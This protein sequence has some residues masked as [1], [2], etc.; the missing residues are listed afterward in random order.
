[1]VCSHAARLGRLNVLAG[2]IHRPQAQPRL[3]DDRAERHRQARDQHGAVGRLYDARTT[4]HLYVIDPAGILVYAGGIDDIRS[5]KVADIAQA[6]NLVTAALADLK[7][8]RPVRTKN[9]QPYGC[10]V[11][12]AD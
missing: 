12:Y 2:D 6:T 11:K 10:A 9:S 8:G 1:M 3:L 4:P 5:S 7:A